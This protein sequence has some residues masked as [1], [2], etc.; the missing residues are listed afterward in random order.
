MKI[1]L[2]HML[3]TLK[4]YFNTA[5]AFLLGIASVPT[6]LILLVVGYVLYV[7]FKPLIFLVIVAGLG[8]MYYNVKLKRNGR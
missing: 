6:L 7:L 4:K 2:H 3:T 5:L 1:N 8:L